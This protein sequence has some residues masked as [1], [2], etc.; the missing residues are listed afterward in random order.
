M[1]RLLRRAQK[2]VSR[3]RR[4]L[5]RQLSIDF[6]AATGMTVREFRLVPPAGGSGTPPRFG[7]SVHGTVGAG[8]VGGGIAGGPGAGADQL[9]TIDQLAAEVGLSTRSIR[10][11]HARGLLPP[12]VRVGR[13]PYYGRA[14]LARMRAVL[15]LQR[16]GLSLDAVRALLEPDTVLGQ[17]L[18]PG[19]LIIAALRADPELFHVLTAAGVLS[20]RPDGGLGVRSARAVL[21]ARAATRRGLPV[22]K[23]LRMLAD[24][25][26]AVLPLAQVAMSRVEAEVRGRHAD[27]GEEDLLEL[28]VEVFRL[29]LM[30]LRRD[31][32]AATGR[33][34]GDR[35]ANR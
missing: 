28:T 30:R 10:S 25:T 31:G 7:G 27:P 33:D 17:L 5:F 12:A 34:T 23:V 22:G 4:I 3:R 24:A 13:T 8:A 18:L 1:G 15:R 14:H 20:Q 11:Y 26:A 21:A 32:P 2:R 29:S 9:L 16:R 35:V 19:N 6:G